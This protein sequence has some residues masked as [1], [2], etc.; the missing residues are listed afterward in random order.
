MVRSTTLMMALS[1]ALAPMTQ[2]MA[3]QAGAAPPADLEA[4]FQQVALQSC[5]DALDHGNFDRWGT[6]E[7]CVADKTHKM[8]RAYRA[9]PASAQ[10]VAGPQTRQPN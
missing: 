3:Q 9:N 7:D 5:N 6:I 8:E 10:A 2:A 1:L 4:K